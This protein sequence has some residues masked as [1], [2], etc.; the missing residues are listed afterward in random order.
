MSTKQPRKP[1]TEFDKLQEEWY[2]KLRES[3]FN[4]I[5]SDEFNLKIWSDRFI[6]QHA[7]PVLWQAKEEY[8]RLAERFLNEHKF[9][10]NLDKVI[11][12]Y[13]ANALS[14]RSIAAL[15]AKANIPHKGKDVVWN[16]IDRLSNCMKRKYLKRKPRSDEQ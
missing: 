13:H 5:E 6:Q 1:K 4:D 8:Y 3:G 12:E 9:E 16:T 14:A 15:L 11:W 7:D 10:S 2:R